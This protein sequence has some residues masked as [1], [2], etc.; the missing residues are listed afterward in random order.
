MIYK[1]NTVT[2]VSGFLLSALLLF[3]VTGCGSASSS[4]T[5]TTQTYTNSEH[6]FSLEVPAGSIQ[7][8]VTLTSNGSTTETGVAFIVEVNTDS[9]DLSK[10]V[11][12]SYPVTAL[13]LDMYVSGIFPDSASI[14]VTDLTVAE[15]P[16]KKATHTSVVGTDTLY[17]TTWFIFYN[18]SVYTLLY[19]SG[20]DDNAIGQAAADSYKFI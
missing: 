5:S 3:S 14:D 17:L 1:T 6:G 18:N 7:S 13:N 16:A 15:N 20:V 2:R 12:I 8:A 9:P 19:S 4:T 10:T 11:S